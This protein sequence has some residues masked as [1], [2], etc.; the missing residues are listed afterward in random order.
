MRVAH[1]DPDGTGDRATRP[2]G[3]VAD[4]HRTHVDAHGVHRRRRVIGHLDAAGAGRGLD[5]E[6]TGAVT[7]HHQCLCEACDAVAAH[8]CR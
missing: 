4:P 8:L 3:R 2:L 1:V 5:P 7:P 6:G